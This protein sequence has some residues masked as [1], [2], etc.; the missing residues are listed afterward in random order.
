MGFNNRMILDACKPVIQYTMSSNK[1]LTGFTVVA[2]TS[3]VCE[4]PIPV[5]VPGKVVDTKG[6]RVEQVGTDPM[7]LWIK[8]D[9]TPSAFVLANPIT[10]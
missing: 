4:V 1:T 2:A 5:T 9:G 8:L 3:N 6:F 7:T 10:L